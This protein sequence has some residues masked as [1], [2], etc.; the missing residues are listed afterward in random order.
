M[1]AMPNR[2]DDGLILIRLSEL[3]QVVT[4]LQEMWNKEKGEE[5]GLD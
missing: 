5:N 2:T 4:K 1:V 3:K